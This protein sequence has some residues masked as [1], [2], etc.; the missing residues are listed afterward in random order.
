MLNSS[1]VSSLGS[2]SCPAL[3][4]VEPLPETT[5]PIQK[6]LSFTTMLALSSLLIQIYKEMSGDEISSRVPRKEI[7]G[8]GKEIPG[9]SAGITPVTGASLVELPL[10]KVARVALQ[11]ARAS[12]KLVGTVVGGIALLASTAIH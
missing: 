8:T 7:L 4:K 6:P 2:E 1:R 11:G 5:D 10:R 3:E 9:T 12:A